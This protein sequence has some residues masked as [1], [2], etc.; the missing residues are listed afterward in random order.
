M[1]DNTYF[2]KLLTHPQIPET[3]RSQIFVGTL[4]NYNCQFCYYGSKLNLPNST[5]KVL[6][7]LDFVHNYGIKDIEFTGGEPSI[8]P[9]WFNWLQYAS[10][11]FRH[12]STITNG[13]KFK[14]Y[15]FTK[16]SRDCGLSE[17][18]FSLHGYDEES[19]EKIT[20][21]KGSW[22]DILKAIKNA[23]KLHIITRI[24]VTVCNLNY[25][26]L[27]R[28]VPLLN[29]IK[30]LGLNYIAL[31][32]WEDA[33]HNNNDIPYELIGEHIEKAI[34]SLD[35]TNIK[36]INIRY[37]PF[38]FIHRKYHKYVCGWH[39]HTYDYWDWNNA[40]KVLPSLKITLN[41]TEYANEIRNSV[42]SKKNECIK[43]KYVAICDGIEKKLMDNNKVYPLKGDIIKD[44][45]VFRKDYCT[46]E[47]YLEDICQK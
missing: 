32:Y 30:P 15:N 45:L 25:Q 42:Y 13:Y 41:S 40:L 22:N 28:Q 6:E 1:L 47:G 21:K 46:L 23:K 18:L 10:K 31:N 38:C 3:N 17:I 2:N 36:Y 19:H 37:L 29:K 4:C 43:C 39:Q 11:K 12:I 16:K 27:E 8:D 7:Q 26:Y 24:N 9:N 14:D 20:R 35:K 44:P 34:N 33:I 5:S